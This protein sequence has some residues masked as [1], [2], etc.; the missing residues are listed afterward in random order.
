MESVRLILEWVGSIAFA[1]CGLPLALE[2]LK[3]KK[4]TLP[5]S[6]LLTWI[7]GEV[8]MLLWALLEKQWVILGANYVPNFV[9]L[10]IVVYYWKR[11]A[12]IK[13]LPA[14]ISYPMVSGLGATPQS[15]DDWLASQDSSKPDSIKNYADFDVDFEYDPKRKY[16]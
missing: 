3:Y 2:A 12:R 6:F 5:L 10:C 13:L 11:P 8:S 1:L 7:T 14:E 16:H 15:L 4:V 9:C